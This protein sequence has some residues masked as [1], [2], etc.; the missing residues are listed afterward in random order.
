M[1]TRGEVN[2]FDIEFNHQLD[3]KRMEK[4]YMKDHFSHTKFIH[5]LDDNEKEIFYIKDHS[6]H[7]KIKLP[8]CT[9]KTHK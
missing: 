9:K 1:I 6:S 5:P 8:V 4:S 3:D 7:T 2:S